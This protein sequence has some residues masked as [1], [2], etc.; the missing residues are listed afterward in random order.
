MGSG[1]VANFELGERSEVTFLYPPFP[2][3]PFPSPLPCP[4]LT[5]FLISLPLELSP[6]KPVRGSDGAL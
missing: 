1:V 3:S 4:S 5:S 6:L 2:Y